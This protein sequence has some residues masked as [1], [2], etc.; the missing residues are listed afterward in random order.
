MTFEQEQPGATLYFD[1][2]CPL[3]MTEM[4]KLQ[5]L[6]DSSLALVDIHSVSDGD[7]LPDRHTL[8]KTLHLRNG[9]GSL[10]TG[11][12]ANI[13]AWQHTQYAARWRLLQLPLVRQLAQAAYHL[14]A[15]W[16]YQRLYHRR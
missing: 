3:C 6:K 9:D 5:Q 7:D 14:W 4:R 13:A 11:L 15:R 2:Q 8:L 10:L 1:S 16:R 12:D